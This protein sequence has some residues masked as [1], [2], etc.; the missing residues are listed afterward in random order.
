MIRKDEL[1]ETQDIQRQLSSMLT[2]ISLLAEYTAS[3]F[4]RLR[5]MVLFSWIE[6]AQ[7]SIKYTL[8]KLK[9]VGDGRD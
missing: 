8:E 4:L 6:T 2:N 7:S 5:L 1:E 3:N 9:E